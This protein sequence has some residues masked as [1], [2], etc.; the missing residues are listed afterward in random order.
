[1]CMIKT[2]ARVTRVATCVSSLMILLLDDVVEGVSLLS[3]IDN[4]TLVII[5][6]Y[7]VSVSACTCIA[8]AWWNEHCMQITSCI[9]M[10]E[11]QN[12]AT[13]SHQPHAVSASQDS[14]FSFVSLLAQP[15]AEQGHATLLWFTL[16]FIPPS[17]CFSLMLHSWHRMQLLYIALMKN[18]HVKQNNDSSWSGDLEHLNSS[19]K[20]RSISLWCLLDISTSSIV[21][22]E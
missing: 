14:R 18:R 5:Y 20:S 8:S 21:W 10:V 4:Y 6:S 12:L 16:R 1:M 15:T 11:D 2:Q 7:A 13:N 9:C 17:T 3:Y 22:I 19:I